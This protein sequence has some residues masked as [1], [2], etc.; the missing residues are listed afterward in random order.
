MIK[1]RIAL[2]LVL[3]ASTTS[4]IAA[5][6]S[7]QTLLKQGLRVD[8][9]IPQKITLA[10]HQTKII[11]LMNITLSPNVANVL[12]GRLTHILNH[13]A[14]MDL[15]KGQD[16]PPAKNIGMNGEAV[17]DQGNWGTCATFSTTAAVNAMFPLAGDLQVSQLCNLEVGKTLDNGGDGGWDGSFGYV[18]LGQMNDYGFVNKQYQHATGCGGLK[19]Y[20]AYSSNDGSAMTTADFTAHS[21]MT[22][23]N[24]DWTPIV[25]YNGSF[26]PLDPTQA[27]TALNNVKA[28]INQGYRVVFGTLIDGNVG[29][30]GAAGSY[31][32]VD[33]D[34]WVMTS[35]IP[36]DIKA[37]DPMEGHEII[38]DGYDDNACATY[39]EGTDTKQ[40][41]GLL[42]IRNS[43]SAAAGYQGDYY[44]TYDHFKGMVIEAYAIGQ[45]VKDN[46]KP[47]TQ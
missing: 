22:F 4:V 1:T 9:S 32:S 5:D 38:I 18:V 31:D 20:P 29:Q 8:G 45:D 19:A 7:Y 33:N 37:G 17:L 6:H 35:Q 41:C 11:R 34:T 3:A 42:E 36:V 28:A 47:V 43:W 15:L 46:F 12:S 13:P 24:T 27:G 14:Q 23:N 21:S 44:M 39:T 10:N 16:V 30:V 25:S 26:A 2:S 40:Q